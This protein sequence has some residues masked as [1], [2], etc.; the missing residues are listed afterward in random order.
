MEGVFK[1][2][3]RKDLVIPRAGPG[4]MP[5]D[6]IVP[7]SGEDGRIAPIIFPLILEGTNLRGPHASIGH[8]HMLTVVIAPEEIGAEGLC[9]TRGCGRYSGNLSQGTVKM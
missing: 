4:Q 9:N 8:A 2:R 5:G 3:I 1:R 6:S 7:H